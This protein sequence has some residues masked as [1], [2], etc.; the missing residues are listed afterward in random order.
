MGGKNS[1]SYFQQTM[2]EV[3]GEL[4]FVSV[5]IYID[6][7]LVYAEDVEKLVI[8]MKAVFLRLRKFGIFLKPK[9]CTLFA[10]SIIWCGHVISEAGCGINEEYLQALQDI[11]EP[12]NAAAL[13]QFLASCNWV[14]DSIPNYAVVVAPLQDLLKTVLAECSRKTTRVACKKILGERWTT[15]EAAAFVDIKAAVKKAVTLA[16]L[17]DDTMVCLFTDASGDFWGAILTQVSVEDVES[18]SSPTLWRHEPL[19]FL[20]GQFRGAQ[21][22]WGIPDKEGYAIRIACEKFAHVL[23]REKGFI[24]FTDHRNLTYIFNPAGVVASVAK[25]QADRLERW[26]MFLRC[27]TYKVRHIAGEANVWADMLSRWGAVGSESEGLAA[28]VREEQLVEHAAQATLRVKRDRILPSVAHAAARTVDDENK[29]PDVDE[30]W[31]SVQEIREAQAE[32]SEA[33]IRDSALIMQDGVLTDEAGHIFVPA[34]PEHLR[35]R[36]L[37]IAH[38]GAAGHRGQAVTERDLKTRFT[39]P[40]LAQQVREFVQRCLLCCKTRGGVV[41]PPPIG[42]ALRGAEPGES[43]HLDFITMFEGEGL[44]VLKDGFSGFVLLWY[45]KAYN[46]LTTEEAVIEWSALFGVPKFL[47]TD[48]GTHFNNQLVEALVTRFRSAHHITTPYAPWANGVI[49]RVN[50]ELLRLWRVLLSEAALEEAKWRTL[51]PLVQAIINR[52]ANAAFDGLSPVEVHLAR[53][54]AIPLDTVAYAGLSAEEQ[55]AM[56]GVSEAEQVR[57]AFEAAAAAVQASWLRVAALREKR[58]EQNRQER[59]RAA[60]RA[61]RVRAAREAGKVPQFAVGE[62]VLISAA[63]PRSKLR[64]RWLGPMRVVSTVNEWVYVLEDVVSGKHRT[65][66]VQRMKLYA[67]AD[68]LVTEDVRNQAAYDDV[69]HID[70]IIDW[71]E[72]DEGDL[73]LRVRWLGFTAS[74]DSWEPVARLHEDQE[75]L[76]ERYL[77]RIQHECDLAVALL[78]SWGSAFAGA[79]PIRGR[80]TGAAA[81]AAGA[82]GAPRRRT[83]RRR[84]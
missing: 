28:D 16:H 48:G 7:V 77:Q 37:V 53:R 50:R 1:A 41:V 38:A 43:L 46:A 56:E 13:R 20:S 69:T 49:E 32:V 66:H 8:A 11:P 45:A 12:L 26:A 35:V 4:L 70:D 75:L 42:K 25:P 82:S 5:L 51:R 40:G 33:V 67:D 74:E 80:G 63:V 3:L 57:A 84:K 14:R 39:W 24:I 81:A 27:F 55:A 36:L 34:Q 71:R 59:E 15:R 23:I 79:D 10:T 44:L 54:V 2:Q 18:G 17:R 64:V 58:H 65:V 61:P 52:T 83:R 6:D 68:F 21:Q 22:R 72:N 47:V 78:A 9:K 62:F 29:L 19:G 31:P 60:G 73:E 30:R 76:V